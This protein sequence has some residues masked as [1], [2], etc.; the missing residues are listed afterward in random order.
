MKVER[1]SLTVTE[2]YRSALKDDEVE[3]VGGAPSSSST[4]K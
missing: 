1:Q 4:P 2:T 3:A